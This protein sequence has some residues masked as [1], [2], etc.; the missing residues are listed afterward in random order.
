MSWKAHTSVSWE[1][2]A[3]ALGLSLPPAHHVQWLRRI[4]DEDAA[5]PRHP[6]R[7]DLRSDHG[8]TLVELLVATAMGL[9][10]LGAVLTM[11]VTSSQVQARDAEWAL[12][13]Q[14]G[15]TGLARMSREIRQATLVETSK[16]GNGKI[17]FESFIKEKPW[18]TE[19]SCE[20]LQSG[21]YQCVRYAAEVVGGKATL[22]AKG[23]VLISDVRKSSVFSYPTT[24]LVTLKVELPAKGTLKQ[25]GSNFYSNY[26]VLE[27]D[28]FMRN[29][30]SS[31]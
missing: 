13:M 3:S 11:L 12:T 20:V 29:L 24:A 2:V 1:G 28:A 14:E 19:L 9:V 15:R 16:S 10:V 31:G 7:A 25:P 18:Q 30:D 8:F 26:I 4:A 5:Y 21:T 6:R 27:N 17:V 22:P 23:T